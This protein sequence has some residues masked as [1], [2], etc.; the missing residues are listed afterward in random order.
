MDS[1]LSDP[2][3]INIGLS[4]SGFDGT[5]VVL[6][7]FFIHFQIGE[8]HPFST[9]VDAIVPMRRDLFDASVKE[10]CGTGK[11]QTQFGVRRIKNGCA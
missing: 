6:N 5:G 8:N 1:P 3:S 2:T 4:A 7:R 10:I 9:G 11:G